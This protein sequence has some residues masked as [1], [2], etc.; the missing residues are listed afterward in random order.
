[1]FQPPGNITR[2]LG[3]GKCSTAASDTA[4][5]TASKVHRYFGEVTQAVGGALPQLW[6]RLVRGS[7]VVTCLPSSSRYCV[8][9]SQDQ[10][11]KVSSTLLNSLCSRIRSERYACLTWKR[12]FTPGSRLAV[13][14]PS[15]CNVCG[16]VTELNVVYHQLAI[17]S[18]V[19]FLV[20][21]RLTFSRLFWCIRFVGNHVPYLFHRS[22]AVFLISYN[23]YDTRFVVN[24]MERCIRGEKNTK[25]K[26]YKGG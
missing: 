22:C 25:Q 10:E 3:D 14:A 15:F 2:T 24:G 4:A 19:F 16:A 20:W 6:F 9:L 17:T 13:G 5:T 18:L 21:R 7:V 1:M 12:L 11:I 26:A 23:E 8:T